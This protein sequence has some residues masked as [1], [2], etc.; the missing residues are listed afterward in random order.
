[1]TTTPNAVLENHPSP[2]AERRRALMIAALASLI[3]FLIWNIAGLAAI[4]APLRLFVTYIHE[5]G[6]ALSALLTGGRVVQFT[7][8]PNGSGLAITGGGTRSIVIA[9]GYLGAA[10]FGS[11]L[12]YLANRYSRYDRLLAVAI[13]VFMVVFTL[14]FARPDEGGN[15]TAIFVGLLFGGALAAIGWAAPRLII[16]LVLDMLA[17]ATALNAV[18]DIWFLMGNIT[19]T[20]GTV[21]NDAVAFSQEITMG[22]VPPTVIALV[23]V[24]VAVLMFALAV[25]HGVWKPLQEEIGSA[26]SRT[27]T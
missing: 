25:Y 2:A 6:H 21:R 15:P 22:L 17:I 10:A 24:G 23:W 16:L 14:A 11:G 5:A 8:S 1:M 12:F 26:Y 27:R 19:A 9:G 18:L 20:R 3:L 4:L 13:G 7:V